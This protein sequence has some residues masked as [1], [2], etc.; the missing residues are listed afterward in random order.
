[1]SWGE[2]NTHIVLFPWT[3]LKAPLQKDAL[4]VTQ[5]TDPGNPLMDE[6]LL[7]YLRDLQGAVTT[8][9]NMDF[10][11]F[12]YVFCWLGLCQCDTS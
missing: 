3:H 4:L 8:I 7:P 11:Y 10:Y 5:E 12:N 1:M 6:G 2:S 9:F